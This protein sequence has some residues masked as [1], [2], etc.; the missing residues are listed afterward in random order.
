MP[1][2]GAPFPD[3]GLIVFEFSGSAVC[4]KLYSCRIGQC[5]CRSAAVKSIMLCN[6]SRMISGTAKFTT[7]LGPS[8]I[9]FDI[10]IEPIEAKPCCKSNKDNTN[11]A[12]THWVA[13]RACSSE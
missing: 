3:C 12:S 7:K 13:S 8:P 4:Y 6:L 5:D 10:R 2:N 11:E 9:R 1:F